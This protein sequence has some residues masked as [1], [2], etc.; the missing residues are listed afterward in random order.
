MK[1]WAFYAAA[2]VI[3]AFSPHARADDSFVEIQGGGAV[4]MGQQT[5]ISMTDEY[6]LIQMS[7]QSYRVNATFRFYN[8]GASTTVAVGFPANGEGAEGAAKRDFDYFK[9]WVNGNI[10]P[11]KDAPDRN[12]DDSDGRGYSYF[13]VKRVYFPASAVTISS[14]EYEAPYGNS[15]NGE[16]WLWYTYGTGG[17]WR[18]PIGRA[19]FDVRFQET[20]KDSPIGI[21]IRVKDPAHLIHR[22]LGQIV[23]EMDDVKPKSVAAFGVDF[24]PLSLCLHDRLPEDQTDYCTLF[25]DDPRISLPQDPQYLSAI[26]YRLRR[27]EIY[28]RHGRIFRDPL[29]RQFFAGR[30]WYQPDPK[31]RGV[32]KSEEDLAL[33][34]GDKEKQLRNSPPYVPDPLGSHADAAALTKTSKDSGQICFDEISHDSD[35]LTRALTAIKHRKISEYARILTVVHSNFNFGPALIAPHPPS[36]AHYF[37]SDGSEQ[38]PLTLVEYSEVGCMGMT[39]ASQL[40]KKYGDRLRVLYKPLIMDS[41]PRNWCLEGPAASRLALAV[42]RQSPEKASEFVDKMAANRLLLYAGNEAAATDFFEGAMRSLNVDT[43]IARRDADGPSVKNQID[44]DH[45]EF[46]DY[47]F[48]SIP[49]YVFNGILVPVGAPPQYYDLIAKDQELRLPSTFR[50]VSRSCPEAEASLADQ[51]DLIIAAL[52][53]MRTRDWASLNKVLSEAAQSQ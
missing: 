35:L 49:A 52:A 43:A 48:T 14:V 37:P 47:G 16:S 29:L 8:S 3:I 1:R 4:T 53:D 30:R 6:V 23:Y 19:I 11:T 15:S 9:T 50:N 20:G 40:K 38:A 27:N 17:S 32:S 24:R 22:S 31:F 44:A 18:G 5:D 41:L 2:S 42:A 21:D 39:I 12:Y 7:S 36:L 13:K 25:V 34:Y 28:A 26:Y 10:V 33:F 46:A 51:P 45:S